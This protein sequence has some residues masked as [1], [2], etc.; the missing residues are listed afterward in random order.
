MASL[1]AANQDPELPVRSLRLVELA[2]ASD[3]PVDL[4]L[5]HFSPDHQHFSPQHNRMPLFVRDVN[6]RKV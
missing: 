3:F 6:K 1:P 2:T 4:Q 5:R